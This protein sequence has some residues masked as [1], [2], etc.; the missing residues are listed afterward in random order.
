[1]IAVITHLSIEDSRPTYSVP[2]KIWVLSIRPTH[3]DRGFPVGR[4]LRGEAPG[5]AAATARSRLR[6]VWADAA[7]TI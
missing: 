2:A 3:F 7:G 4:R 6:A 5:G 1:M